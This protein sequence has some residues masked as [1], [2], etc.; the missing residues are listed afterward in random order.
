MILAFECNTSTFYRMALAWDR[1]SVCFG[2]K[3]IESLSQARMASGSHVS[4]A[5]E[6]ADRKLLTVYLR[7]FNGV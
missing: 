3:H 4:L 2:P 5:A 1:L 6:D 7:I